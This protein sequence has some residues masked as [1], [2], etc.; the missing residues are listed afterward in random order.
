MAIT[1]AQ[2]ESRRPCTEGRKR[3]SP[4]EEATDE[5]FGRHF[6]LERVGCQIHC[7]LAEAPDASL[8]GLSHAAVTDHTF[9]T[10]QM[11]ALVPHYRVL[12]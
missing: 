7:W 3:V 5:T 9:F 6:T 1:D 8:V 12:T 2:D 4:D 10:A 11:P